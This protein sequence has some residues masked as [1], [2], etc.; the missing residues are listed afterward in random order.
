MMSVSFLLVF[1]AFNGTQTIVSSL[2]PGSLG[3]WSV[4]CIYISFTL[5]SLLF[6][7]AFVIAT[8]TKISLAVGAFLYLGFIGANIYPMWIT[9]V[10]AAVILGFGAAIIWTAQGSYVTNAAL[11]YAKLSNK[12]PRSSIGLFNG[13]FFGIFQLSMLIGNILSSVILSSGGSSSESLSDLSGSFFD[14]SSSSSEPEINPQAKILFYVYTA[15]CFVGFVGLCFLPKAN[16]ADDSPKQKIKNPIEKVIGA[17]VL[18]KEPRMFLMIPYLVFT[19]LE[20]AFVFGDFTKQFVRELHGVE[21]VGYVMSSFGAID[22]IC[23]FALGRLADRIGA[24]WIGYSGVVLMTVF[25][26][27][28]RFFRDSTFGVTLPAAFM[29]AALLGV[30]DACIFSVFCNAA[31]ATLFPDRAEAAFSNVKVFQAGATG[32]MFF[33]GPLLTFDIKIYILAASLVVAVICVIILDTRVYSLGPQNKN[34]EETDPLIADSDA[35]VN[36]SA[37]DAGSSA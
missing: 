17:I 23:S 18:W 8:S 5:S 14:D 22:S 11:C 4:A 7:S 28:I 20:Q 30:G 35:T 34:Q 15:V 19:G 29:W 1:L 24:R 32:L 21:M 13:I 12:P 37:A 2:L 3:Y 10:I 27:T 16:S 31:M 25:L 9:L 6:S 36:T 33:L 26:G